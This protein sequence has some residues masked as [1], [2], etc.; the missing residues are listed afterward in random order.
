MKNWIVIA[1]T[2]FLYYVMGSA[3]H[4]YPWPDYTDGCHK[5]IH[6]QFQFHLTFEILHYQVVG[7]GS[8]AELLII[9]SHTY[10]IWL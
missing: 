9:I 7:W 10:C 4:K 5:C 1:S 8:A 3:M 2:K 6:D